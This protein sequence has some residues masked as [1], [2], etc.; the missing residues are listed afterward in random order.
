MAET[1]AV[2]DGDHPTFKRLIT[3]Y[4]FCCA[5]RTVLKPTVAQR[6]ILEEFRVWEHPDGIRRY[7]FF[8]TYK[9]MISFQTK[10]V[11]YLSYRG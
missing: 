4:P 6:G 2:A 7:W 9:G 11:N 10:F 8:K 1:L 5:T 3:D